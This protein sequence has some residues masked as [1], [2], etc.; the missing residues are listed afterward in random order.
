MTIQ[1]RILNETPKVKG[2]CGGCFNTTTAKTGKNEKGEYIK[3]CT[4]GKI[5]FWSPMMEQAMSNGEEIKQD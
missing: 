1:D 2:F 3:T 4:C 5:A